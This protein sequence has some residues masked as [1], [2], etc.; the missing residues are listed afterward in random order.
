MTETKS[1]AK[2][3]RT[4]K[5][6]TMDGD[7]PEVKPLEG[8][9]RET[10]TISVKDFIYRQREF[11]ITKKLEG[12]SERTLKDYVKHFKYLNDW[13]VQEYYE[14]T[15][16]LS[17]GMEKGIFLGYIGYMIS[18]YKPCTVNIRL[19]NI[20]CYLKYLFAE[21]IMKEDISAKLK[22]VRVPK[23]MIQP[24]TTQEI[25]KMIKSLDQSKYA[26]YRD[27]CLILLFLDT[28]IRVNEACNIMM[29]DIDKRNKLITV[30]SE[31]AKTR[32]E[33]VL[34][35]STKTMKYLERLISV[36]ENNEELYIFNSTYGGK[37]DT[38]S[39]IKRFEKH[40]KEVEINKRCTPHVFRH[41]MALNAVKA[42]LDVFTLQKLLGHSS[43]STTRLYVQLSTEDLQSSHSKVNLLNNYI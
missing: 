3:R 26:D 43:L 9:Q 10:G 4:R 11:M 42:G 2:G 18:K 36:A 40:G 5:K 32:E 20:K 6:L 30:R 27:L 1:E 37:I 33:R 31:V 17:R 22:L 38:L 35:I 41:T 14:E 15:D 25:K 24:L 19:R 34:P 39:I 12:L 16:T 29:S 28:G 23:D 21:G 13:I 8:N 7:L